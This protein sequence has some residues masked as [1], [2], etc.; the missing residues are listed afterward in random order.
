MS[1]RPAAQVLDRLGG[2]AEVFGLHGAERGRAGR[3]ELDPE[4]ARFAPLMAE[5][6]SEARTEVEH[7]GLPGVV[8]EDKGVIVALHHRAAADQQAAATALERLAADLAAR[9]GLERASGRKVIELRPPLRFSKAKVITAEAR[10]RALAAA[11]F[12]GDDMV[13]LPAF[14]ALDEL[15]AAGLATVRIAVASAEAPPELL[16]RADVVVAGPT[17]LLDLLATLLD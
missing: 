1:G 14:D 12:A 10:R 4:A 8:V 7:L 2:A 11:A 3:V 13:D 5:V 9:Y 6:L 16:A 15:A 17:E